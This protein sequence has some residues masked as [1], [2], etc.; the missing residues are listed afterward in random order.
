M[1]GTDAIP[2]QQKIKGIDVVSPV[3]A[4]LDLLG[5]KGRGEEAAQAILDKEYGE[6]I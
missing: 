1:P 4:C 5:L 2:I 3:Q 6:I